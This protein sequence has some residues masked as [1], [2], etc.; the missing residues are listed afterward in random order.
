[1]PIS[2]KTKNKRYY[3]AHREHLLEK[4]KEKVDKYRKLS[5]KERWTT[6]RANDNFG[7]A[8]KPAPREKMLAWIEEVNRREENAKRTTSL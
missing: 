4:R 1:M 7:D 8:E 6:H 3:L 2:I 5:Y